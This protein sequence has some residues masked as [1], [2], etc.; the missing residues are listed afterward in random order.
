M[1]S[2]IRLVPAVAVALVACGEPRP[3]EPVL[4]A[5]PER[6]S[7]NP[8][9]ERSLFLLDLDLED[10]HGAP[11]ELISARGHPTLVTFF[12]A[13][14]RTVCPRAISDVRAL[15]AGLSAEARDGLRVVLVTLDPERDDAARLAGVANERGVPLDR[16][17]LVRGSE[18]DTRTLASTVGMTYRR[19]SD[20]EIAHA[21]VFTLLDGEG[22]TLV[23]SIDGGRSLDAVADAIERAAGPARSAR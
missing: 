17:S 9:D 1:R 8:I 12:Y 22:R 11:F 5:E 2:L 6:L 18:R 15:E 20:G 10:E 3:P 23:Q 19:T 4:G 7:T 14:C 21:I 13:S 16:W